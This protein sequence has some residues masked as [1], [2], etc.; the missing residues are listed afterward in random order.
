MQN[1]LPFVIRVIDGRLFFRK[2]RIINGKIEDADYYFGEYIG[3]NKLEKK[4]AK[5]YTFYVTVPD[6]ST[7]N[8]IKNPDYGYSS[9]LRELFDFYTIYMLDRKTSH[10]F[11]FITYDDIRENYLLP[12]EH[13][14]ALIPFEHQIAGAN[15]IIKNK[16]ALLF[17]ETGTGKSLAA[18]LAFDYLYHNGEVKNAL[19]V[20]PNSLVLN[21]LENHIKSAYP[22]FNFDIEN[23]KQD[24]VNV[25]PISDLSVNE[26]ITLLT[27]LQK[28]KGVIVITNYDTFSRMP[29][30]D[31]SVS[32][33]YVIFDESHF[34][35]NNSNRTKR[36]RDFIDFKYCVMLT[37]TPIDGKYIDYFNQ[38]KICEYKEPFYVDNYR[39][40]EA[41][42]IVTNYWSRNSAN[43][44]RYVDVYKILRYINNNSFELRKEQCLDLP[45]KIYTTQPIKLYDE[46]M[47]E[48]NKFVS[49]LTLNIDDIQEQIDTLLAKLEYTVDEKDRE[50][51]I[52]QLK[53]LTGRK[54]KDYVASILPKILYARMLVSGV[55]YSGKNAKIDWLKENLHENEK[56]VIYCDFIHTVNRLYTELK[57]YNPEFLI[58]RLYGYTSPEKRHEIVQKFNKTDEVNIIIANPKVGGIGIDLTAAHTCI[59]YENDLSYIVRKQA[60]D[61]LHRIGQNNKVEYIDLIAVGTIDNY[62]YELIMEKK[63][64]TDDI[65]RI[66]SLNQLKEIMTGGRLQ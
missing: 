50:A 54:G 46:H 51:I 31:A 9:F 63:Q 5:D 4:E 15:F 10:F 41:R 16:K 49:T 29:D 20:C 6:D 1:K 23:M 17:W 52:E 27:F 2:G 11:G 28:A 30:L 19:I 53:A 14:S 3:Y 61:R 37:G 45:D 55:F 43:R 36:I 66:S 18:L 8:A 56:Y 26:R 24:A 22:Q 21:W 48:Y 34:M 42:Y 62:V 38:F 57:E 25:I 64:V 13:H 44:K 47:T 35:K 32:F 39:T 33:D 12:L 65:Y 59:F 7:I 60:E 58:E 40:F